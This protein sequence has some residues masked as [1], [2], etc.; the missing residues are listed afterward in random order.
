MAAGV[1]GGAAAVRTGKRAFLVCAVAYLTA[2]GSVAVLHAVTGVTRGW[3][4]V[5]FL[6]L[7]GGVAQLLLGPGLLAL[8]SRSGAWAPSPRQVLAELV[9][10]NG[11]TAAV[12]IADL[13][14]SMAGVLAGS[15]LLLAALLLF[16]GGLRLARATAPR[17][18]PAW[19]RAYAFL[20]AF[21]AISVI[22][23]AWLAYVR[24][25]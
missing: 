25:R 17:R 3:W 24:G 11:G 22:V 8:A 19:G 2:A 21:L 18:W 23:G 5:A 1:K 14:D 6:S 13:A 9:L 15:V 16:A 20:L 10:W 7:V 4:L 12:A